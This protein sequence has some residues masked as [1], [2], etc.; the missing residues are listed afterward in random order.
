MKC[1]FVEHICGTYSQEHDVS[2]KAILEYLSGV[3]LQVQRKQTH[4]PVMDASFNMQQVNVCASQVPRGDTPPHHVQCII[5]Y[6]VKPV[7]IMY[8][9]DYCD[10]F[11]S[12]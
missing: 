6:L 7:Y 2:L 4:R 8:V 1:I 11:V 10:Y 9:S 3:D 5:S 12:L